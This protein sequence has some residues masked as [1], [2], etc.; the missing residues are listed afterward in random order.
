MTAI[1]SVLWVFP[2]EIPTGGSKQPKAHK[3]DGP[4]CAFFPGCS[5]ETFWSHQGMESQTGQANVNAAGM[6]AGNGP[7][8]AP[9]TG[10]DHIHL[11]LQE[12][13]QL[14]LLLNC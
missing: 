13:S 4:I 9:P 6:L 1:S 10:P 7:E 12:P 5:V 2:R 11:K 14:F 8:R 3:G